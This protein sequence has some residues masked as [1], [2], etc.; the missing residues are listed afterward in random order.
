[1]DYYGLFIKIMDLQLKESIKKL[2]ALIL[3]MID[4]VILSNEKALE[5]I[6]RLIS[7]RGVD[8]F[9]VVADFDRTLT[10]AFVE[11]EK[12][13]SLIAILRDGSY[14]TKDYAEKAHALFG[15][16]HPIEIDT[17]ISIENKK[18]EMRKWWI[19]HADLLVKSGLNKKDVENVAKSKKIIFREG[20]LEFIDNLYQNNI[21]LVIISSGGLGGVP[22]LMCLEREGKRYD[23]IYLVA[24]SYEWDEKG[25]AIKI[26]EP[27]I[28]SVNKDETMIRNFPFF[29]IIKNRKNVL[30]LGDSLEDVNMIKGF[31]YD[32]LIKIGFLNEKIE[33]N[34]NLYKKNYDI[35][36]LNDGS[37]Q[38]VSELLR[39]LFN[40]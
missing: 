13:H 27:I 11:G 28:T 19:E 31:D 14:L 5:K 1:M 32:N 15:K 24:N 8:N 29:D 37:M 4:D 34:L 22:I 2:W 7:S 36:I 10:K 25:N 33:E 21:P 38:Y 18:R 40:R 16:Y 30:L 35:V 3:F 12:F 6:K 9:H 20:T 39:D 26:N 23:N 17:N